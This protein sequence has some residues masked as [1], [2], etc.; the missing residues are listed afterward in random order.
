MLDNTPITKQC[1][2]CEIE[3]EIDEFCKDSKTKDGRYYEC[4]KCKY[5]RN[6]KWNSENSTRI[7]ELQKTRYENNKDSILRQHKEYRETHKEQINILNKKWRE[8][9]KEYKNSNDRKYRENRPEQTRLY[10]EEWE[11]K[12]PEKTKKSK[13]TSLYNRRSM[14]PEGRHTVFEWECLKARYNNSCL[15]CGRDDIPITEDHIIPVTKGGSNYISNI[16]PL[17]GSCNSKKHTKTTD[18]RY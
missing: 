8:E 6:R 7:K 18:Y 13:R 3:K 15:R 12:N 17:C 9:N 2:T 11:K 5:K 10:W 4:K 16:Q 1:P 14:T